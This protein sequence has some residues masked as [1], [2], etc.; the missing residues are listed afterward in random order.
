MSPSYAAVAV[1]LALCEYK[2]SL[3]PR[4]GRICE[5][6][7][8]VDVSHAISGGSLQYYAHGH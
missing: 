1:G 7:A 2:G 8:T 6:N 5:V 4:L 3:N